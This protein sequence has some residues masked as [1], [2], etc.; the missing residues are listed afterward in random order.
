MERAAAAVERAGL[1]A[2][3]VAVV[4]GIGAAVTPAARAQE[5]EPP[6]PQ[7]EVEE[8]RGVESIEEILAQEQEMLSGEGYFYDAGG[9]RD[10]FRSE[11]SRPGTHSC[12]KTG[13]HKGAGRAS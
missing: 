12:A 2:L 11:N 10:P 13:A 7:Q 1:L 8:D 4:L 3:G 9:R 5:A 6:A